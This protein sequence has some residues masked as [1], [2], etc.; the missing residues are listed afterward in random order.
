MK[1]TA[2]II[3]ATGLTGGILLEYL[4]NDPT[5][6]K[7]ILFSRKPIEK[8]HPKIEE[9]L[10]DLFEL[11]NYSEFF[12]ADVVFC[13]IGSTKAKTPDDKIYRKVDYGIP[14]TAAKLAKQNG[15]NTFIIIS[16]L[17]ADEKSKV[18]YNKLKGDMERDV[19]KENIQNTYILRPSLIVG[20]RNEK[21]FG[22]DTAGFFMGV[23]NFLIPKRYKRI[24]ADIIAKA[25]QI[26][27]VNGYSKEIIS[28]E[29]IKEIVE[30]N[31]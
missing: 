23:F 26:L 21:R 27:A 24:H 31:N 4:L 22:E 10:L 11:E 14:I 9:Y 20:D 19:S 18:F 1:K 28:S 25:M 13:C 8:N 29:E 30:K 3:G 5:Y 2:I 7:I 12:K 17:G 15:I 6:E 16:A